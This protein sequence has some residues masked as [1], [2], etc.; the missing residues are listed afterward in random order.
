MAFSNRLESKDPINEV[1]P[2]SLA[3]PTAS[4]PIPDGITSL[5]YDY[6]FIDGLLFSK[7][8][9]MQKAFIP[10]LLFSI[11]IFLSST[12]ALAEMTSVSSWKDIDIIQLAEALK[13]AN[14]REKRGSCRMVELP[15]Y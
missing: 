9:H 10:S 5:I 6:A 4:I 11:G 15:H 2:E 1:M 3:G 7:G 14:E 8:C 13:I 12:N